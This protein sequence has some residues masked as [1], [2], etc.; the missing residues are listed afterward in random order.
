MHPISIRPYQ[1]AD[2]A[3]IQEITY[4]TGFKGEDMT[5]RG[6]CDDARLWFLI[7]I[8]Y[9]TRYEP[10]HFFVAEDKGNHQV[11]GFICG[12]PD[13]LAQE[14]SFRIRMVPRIV[15]RLFGYTSWH[16]PR[17]FKTV[18]KMAR[19]YSS[20]TE[21]AVND[22]IITAYPAH[23]HINILPG[24]QGRSVGSRLIAKFEEHMRN[25]RIPGIHLGTTNKNYKAVP[26]YQKMG[27]S[28]VQESEIVPHPDFDDLKYLMFAKKLQT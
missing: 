19:Q 28:I 1:S 14:A 10:E 16:Y 9:Y 8:A 15:L 22:P 17:S 20:G 7:F 27:Y 4:R 26:F 18:F 2:E 12:T 21:D 11:I 3:A 25:L 24:Y 13:T 23:L 6:F 5:G